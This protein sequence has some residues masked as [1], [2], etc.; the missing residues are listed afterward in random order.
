MAYSVELVERDFDGRVEKQIV[1]S[2]GDEV[3][4]SLDLDEADN[5]VDQI[6]YESRTQAGITR[7]LE[8]MIFR[9]QSLLS[10]QTEREDI[11]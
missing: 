8:Q 2:N 10:N 5:L 3:D 9:V 1:V 11:W 4:F 7:V 6:I